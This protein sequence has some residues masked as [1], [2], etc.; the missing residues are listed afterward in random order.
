[1]FRSNGTFLR[2]WGSPGSGDGEFSGPW[3]VAVDASGNVIVAET[4]NHRIQVFDSSGDFLREWG[5]PGS[6]DGQFSVGVAVDASGNVIVADSATFASRYSNRVEPSCASGVPQQAGGAEAGN[7]AAHR[8][9]RWM[10][11]EM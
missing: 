8:A 6:G 7:L 11:L 1:M 3:G 2:K 9:W 10:P 4:G 5:S